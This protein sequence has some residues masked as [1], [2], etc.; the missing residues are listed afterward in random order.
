MWNLIKMDFY[1]LFSSKTVKVGAIMAA[2]VCGA[3]ML[4]SLG[5][6]ELAK[7]AAQSD[8]D[9]LAGMGMFLAQ[10]SWLEGVD[11]A[12]IVFGATATF[13]LFIGCMISANFIGYE[14][15]CGYTKNYAGQLPNKGYMAVSKF[16]V[17]SIAQ[18]M[19]LA[20]YT[21][22]ASILAVVF[23]GQCISGYDIGALLAALALRLLLYFA[24][25]A[26]IIFVCTLTKSHSVAMVVGCIFG[27]GIT[28]FA[29]MAISVVLG[30]LKI[31]IP[32]SDLMPD[33][34]DSQLAIGSVGELAVKAILVSIVFTAAFIAANYAI[35]RKR[36]V[37]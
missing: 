21:V 36:D 25:N 13:S 7:F 8:P 9:S 34:L 6:I 24:I 14:Q 30:M 29:Y 18:V 10:V 26:V 5:I 28:K 19:V 2:A 37:R 11:F 27:I 3:Y 33:G 12:E 15:S 35:L 4:F 32:I 31:N 16:V 22:V 20:I 17:T 1:R 23:F